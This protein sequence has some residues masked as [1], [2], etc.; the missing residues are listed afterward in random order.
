MAL[1]DS[2]MRIKMVLRECC[3]YLGGAEVME[4]HRDLS[5]AESSL[6]AATWHHTRHDVPP[7][8]EVMT[9]S[10]VLAP[11]EGRA[12]PSLDEGQLFELC[13]V[14]GGGLRLAVIPL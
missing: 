6:R 10:T 4:H 13:V 2:V 11:T 14:M 5:T 8:V 3:D 7:I 9:W 1:H 12:D